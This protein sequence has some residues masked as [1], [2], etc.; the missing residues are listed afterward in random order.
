MRLFHLKMTPWPEKNVPLCQ[1][2]EEQ[3]KCKIKKK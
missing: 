3:K 2:A 1:E